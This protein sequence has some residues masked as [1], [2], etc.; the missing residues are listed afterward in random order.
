MRDSKAS[1]D[2]AMMRARFLWE[3]VRTGWMFW[4]LAI[5][6]GTATIVLPR[7]ARLNRYES[8]PF[9]T[10]EANAMVFGILVA[11]LIMALRDPAYGRRWAI[12]IALAPLVETTIRMLQLG[13]GNLWPIAIFLALVLGFAPAFLGLWLARLIR[14]RRRV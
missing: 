6:L 5:A 13:S 14:S 8:G 9:L 3:D 1:L 10:P 7:A 4:V 2:D 11:V 12:V